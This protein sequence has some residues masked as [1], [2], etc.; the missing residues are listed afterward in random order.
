M[1]NNKTFP[2]S[3]IRYEFQYFSWDSWSTNHLTLE[4]AEFTDL[5]QCPTS[6]GFQFGYI[7][8]QHEILYCTTLEESRPQP[9]QKSA[10]KPNARTQIQ[11]RKKKKTWNVATWYDALWSQ[12][13]VNFGSE[14]WQPQLNQFRHCTPPIYKA[15]RLTLLTSYCRNWDKSPERRGDCRDLKEP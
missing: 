4:L 9:N 1:P 5:F 8:W 12:N 6:P 7:C 14:R 3:S 11:T 2:M 10:S 13:W 15:S